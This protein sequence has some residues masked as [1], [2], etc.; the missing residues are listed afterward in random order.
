MPLKGERLAVVPILWSTV[1]SKQN[2]IQKPAIS[3]SSMR[4]IDAVA[5]AAFP[6]IASAVSTSGQGDGQVNYSKIFGGGLSAKASIHYPG[7]ADYNT[8]TVP[9]WSTWEEPTFA[10]T[11][12]PATDKDVQYIVS[13]QARVVLCAF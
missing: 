2:T 13:G 11:I 4:F 7:Q 10:V 12:Q 9:R 3:S 6:L 1:H 8:T 5:F